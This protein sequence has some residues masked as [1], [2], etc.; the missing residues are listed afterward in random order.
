MTVDNLIPATGWQARLQLGF[1]RR[2]QRT[3]LRQCTH[4][5]PL[6]GIAID[7]FHALAKAL[8]NAR[9]RCHEGDLKT[10][11]D[12]DLAWVGAH[13]D[14]ETN[15]VVA[16]TAAAR[17]L[18]DLVRLGWQAR[19]EGYGLELV[20]DKALAPHPPAARSG[21]YATLIRPTSVGQFSAQLQH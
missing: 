17:V 11:L 3:V 2:E 8:T 1:Q 19:E 21:G 14:P 16:Y 18:V 9:Q 13:L 20:A 12:E 5:G 6:Q 15:A 10:L 4:Q 7:R